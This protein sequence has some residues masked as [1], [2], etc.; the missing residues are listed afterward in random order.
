MRLEEALEASRSDAERLARD[1]AD[2]SAARDMAERELA[3]LGGELLQV[4]LAE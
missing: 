2:A 1:V 3:R 4:R